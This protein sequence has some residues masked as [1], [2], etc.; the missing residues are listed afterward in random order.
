MILKRTF[1]ASLFI[2]VFY[3]PAYAD[4]G[5]IHATDAK[6]SEES[7]K[8]IILHNHDEEVLILGTDLKA[9]K[10]TGLI[11]FIPFP[12]EP[13]VSLAPADVFESASQLIKKHGLKF[14]SKS[15]GGT[16]SAQAVEMRFH[17]KLG[18]HDVTVIK[19]NDSPHFREWVNDFFQKKGLPQ[20]EEYPDVEGIVNDYVKRGITYFVFDFV[21]VTNETHLIEPIVYSF[22][23]KELYYPLKTSNTFGGKGSIDLIFITAKTLCKPSVFFDY[24]D[25]KKFQCIKLPGQSWE[26]STSAN[27]SRNEVKDIYPEA[28]KFFE[29]KNIFIQ[30][31]EYYGRYEF[32]D[33]IFADISKALPYAIGHTEEHIGSPPWIFPFEDILKDIKLLVESSDTEEYI[34]DRKYFSILIPKG[35]S[36]DEAL[37]TRRNMKIFGVEMAI[38]FRGEDEIPPTITVEYYAKDNILYK[39]PEKFIERLSRPDPTMPSRGREYGPVEPTIIA[40]KKARQ[41]ERKIPQLIPPHAVEQKEIQIYEK[42]IVVWA[43][44][45]FYI[46][47]YQC[48]M[49][50]AKSNIQIFEKVVSSFKPFIPTKDFDDAERCLLQ[51]DSGPCKGLFWKYYFNQKTKKC[52]KFA[53]GG[54][55][56]VVPFETQQECENLCIKEGR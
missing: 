52:E 48:P 33:D 44:E 47:T 35:W 39:T 10:K 42:Y 54:C 20:R 3:A 2:I 8:A 43:K 6:V 30:F 28:E 21:E 53:W 36:K 50:S 31:I 25:T 32:E 9:D 5:R 7:Q 19:V 12:S 4:M 34:S 27:I 15:K 18:A 23:S 37:M 14:L 38:P 13:Q 49:K 56:G 11:R 40:G 16:T 29:N 24:F 51:P 45:G 17:K 22:K 55:D 26:A 1:F 41:F 46:L